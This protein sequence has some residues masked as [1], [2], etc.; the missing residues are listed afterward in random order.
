MKHL[1]DS[2]IQSPVMSR[3]WRFTTGALAICLSLAACRE[4][5]D[6]SANPL[7]VIG[8]DGASWTAIRDMWDDGRLR[9]LQALAA[10]GIT[11]EMQPIS[12][13]SPVIWTS[14][15]TGVKPVLH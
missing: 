13:A 9:N 5:R 8:I 3:G 12:D 14:I 6:Q 7:I 11:A 2:L 10:R 15:A 1:E 4:R